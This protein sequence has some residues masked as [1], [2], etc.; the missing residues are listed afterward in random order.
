MDNDRDGRESCDSRSS[1]DGFE[2]PATSEEI[3][4]IEGTLWKIGHKL[5]QFKSRFYYLKEHFLY[6]FHSR[7]DVEPQGENLHP[8]SLYILCIR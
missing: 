5:R 7:E 6:Q 3:P 4:H 1:Y 8:S 2:D